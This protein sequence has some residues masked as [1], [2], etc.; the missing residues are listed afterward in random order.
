MRTTI[1]IPGILLI[2]S[3][4]VQCSEK[5][6]D[7][8]L[9]SLKEKGVDVKIIEEESIPTSQVY[10]VVETLSLGGEEVP[11]LYQP[12]S[13]LVD[14]QGNMY[15]TDENRIKKFSPDGEF[16]RYI[17]DIGQGPGEVEYPNLEV[18][19]EGNLVVG[20]GISRGRRKYELFNLNGDYTGRLY[21]PELKEKLIPE[22]RNLTIS[23]LGNDRFLIEASR[24]VP[25]E[26]LIIL[27]EKKYAIADKEGNLLKELEFITEPYAS[28]VQSNDARLSRPLTM[29]YPPSYFQNNLYIL[30]RNGKDICIFSNSGDLLKITRINMPESKTTDEEKD[31]ITKKYEGYG[32]EFSELLKI[33]GIPDTKPGL[34]DILLDDNDQVWLQKGDTFRD[35][36]Y[37]GV[38]NEYTYV[39]LDNGGNCIGEQVLPVK[40][41]IVK[42]EQ[43]YGFMKNEEGF[44]VFKRYRLKTK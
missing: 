27:Y 33:I 21:H 26:K 43:A 34:C 8:Y 36:S 30:N 37:P 3:L 41:D 32:G 23:Y 22:G 16:L 42:N 25:Q 28:E 10:D 31:A 20:Q 17:G 35:Y 24:R 40:V 38:D 5:I 14:D 7:P 39:I 1:K 29:S 6:E 44:R 12:G 11:T 18:I 2:L 13:C 9:L 19:R 15:F 4:L